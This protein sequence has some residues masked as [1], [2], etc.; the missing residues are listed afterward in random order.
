MAESWEVSQDELEW[1]FR[2]RKNVRWSDGQPFSAEDALFTMQIVNDSKIASPARDALTIRGKPIQ[3]TLL[4]SHSI[5]ALL[6][7]KH[8]TFLRHLDPEFVRFLKTSLGEVLQ[9]RTFFRSS[10][11]PGNPIAGLGPFQF[12]ALVPGQKL[13]LSRN[14]HY[15]KTDKQGARLPYLEELVFMILPNQDQ[16]QLKIENNEIDTYQNIRAGDVQRL[17]Q[18]ADALSM[19]ITNI[20][21][22]YEMEGFF[23]NQNRSIDP[24][25][26]RP[27]VDPVKLSWFTDTQF[28]RAVSHAIDRE[29]LVR[30]SLFGQGIP[31]F[32]ME[33]P[34]NK[35]WF[36][37]DIPRYSHDVKKAM[38]L[39]VASGFSQKTNATGKPELYDK[40]GNRV[41]F[42]L[43]T[44]ANSTIRN[45]QCILIASD[46]AKLGM[47]VQYTALDFGTLV[48]HVNRTY[49]YD[50]VLL[51]LNRDDPDSRS[52][53]SST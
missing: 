12:K 25:T 40:N 30:N 10:T 31:A 47:E 9:R 52:G 6:P 21:P 2:L 14:P 49:Q 17:E 32:N 4:D 8:V 39:L 16:I 3:W 35:I 33:T 42:S 15:W 38:S 20:G 48:H 5:K 46:L 41:R 23:F 28:R 7:S 13:V 29:A 19:K 45:T 43:Y 27:V 36:Y 51:G 1:T 24:E 18:K 37:P 11:P 44:N 50:A 34:G 53:F 26:K 22:T